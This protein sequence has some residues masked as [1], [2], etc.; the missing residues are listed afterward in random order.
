MEFDRM[1]CARRMDGTLEMD[2]E[3]GD[4]MGAPGCS[5]GMLLADDDRRG[6]NIGGTTLLLILDRI[7]GFNASL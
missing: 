7:C 3:D 2:A 6:S 5:D 1:E 4:E